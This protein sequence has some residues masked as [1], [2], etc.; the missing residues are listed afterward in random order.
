MTKERDEDT[1]ER[2]QS[3]AFRYRTPRRSWRGRAV[4]A[5]GRPHTEHVQQK[6]FKGVVSGRP[7]VLPRWDAHVNE[8]FLC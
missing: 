5:A 2:L 6:H 4:F 7:D 8:A 3:P 1:G